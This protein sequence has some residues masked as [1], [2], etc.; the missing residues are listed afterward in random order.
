M[1]FF[2]K[3]ELLSFLKNVLNCLKYNEKNRISHGRLTPR[4]FVKLP[5]Q[6]Y[7][8]DGYQ[9]PN[10][11]EATKNLIQAPEK[12]KSTDDQRKF[13]GTYI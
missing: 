4:C 7:Y 3:R 9:T 13:E 12:I 6:L 5:N 1:D 2:S 10:F 8:L 11:D